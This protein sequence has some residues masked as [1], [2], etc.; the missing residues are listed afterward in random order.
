MINSKRNKKLVKNIAI[1]FLVCV[2]LYVIKNVFFYKKP[3]MEGY[4]SGS[5]KDFTGYQTDALSL[6]LNK[7]SKGALNPVF[8]EFN[9]ILSGVNF[10]VIFLRGHFA[11]LF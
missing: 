10:S 8:L 11:I 4:T 6:K 5:Y 7:L 9:L 3:I 1:I 2:I